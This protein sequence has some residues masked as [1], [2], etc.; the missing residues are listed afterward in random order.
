MAPKSHVILEEPS[1]FLLI[2]R[3]LSFSG[4]VEQLQSA[5]RPA[6]AISST[7]GMSVA[8]TVLK[9]T[10]IYC[11]VYLPVFVSVSW[12]RGLLFSSL[13]TCRIK[14]RRG[15]VVFRT[16]S[17]SVAPKKVITNREWMKWMNKKPF[18]HSTKKKTKL[19]SQIEPV[20]NSYEIILAL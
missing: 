7:G 12:V 13:T 3:A 10:V 4:S 6:V 15:G 11:T 16:N 20:R 9:S 5:H 17:V 2:S 14:G 19:L 1:K 18:I 8:L